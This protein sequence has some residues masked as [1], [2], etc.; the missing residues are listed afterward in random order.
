MKTI[1]FDHQIG[2]NDPLERERLRQI[3][4]DRLRSVERIVSRWLYLEWANNR[5][6]LHASRLLLPGNIHR[7][8][9][10]DATARASPLYE[11][12]DD[13][14]VLE[15][16]PGAR[17]YRKVSLHVSRG[18]RVGKRSTARNAKESFAALVG[19]LNVRLPGR[20]ALIICHKDVEPVLQGF[21]TTFTMLTAHW[22]EIAGQN[23]WKD[24]DAV[25][26]S[27]LPYRPE[28]W[29][30]NVFM[31]AKGAQNTQWLRSKEKRA[32]GRHA[33]IRKA[34]KVGQLVTDIVQAINRVQCRKVIDALGNC[35][36]TDAFILLPPG[37]IADEILRGIEA[38]MPEINIREDWDYSSQK[39]RARK[40]N[41][42]L[43]LITFL[44]NMAPGKQLA[45]GVAKELGMS[46]KTM[47]RLL[48][49]SRSPGDDL[50]AAMSEAGVQ[51]AAL[52]EGKTKKGYFIKE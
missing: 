42:E 7:A 22:G 19:D 50:G 5:H 33:D 40:S 37:D 16:P 47:N 14:E 28:H 3:H 29:T 17:S 41:H 8:V 23:A 31:A 52:R 27:S 36:E 4:D 30:A 15:S 49:K 24:C 35:P 46:P 2:R 13:V 34:I 10:L 21:K 51:Y 6:T 18:H 9:I 38:Q 32:F 25:V 44:R 26:I 11:L 45:S 12:L 39:K 20:K 43:A 1:P 48:E